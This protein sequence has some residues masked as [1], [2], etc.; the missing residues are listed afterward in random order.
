M[1][2]V[3]QLNTV[4]DCKKEFEKTIKELA[5][6]RHMWEVWSDFCELAAIGIFNPFERLYLTEHSPE[7]LGTRIQNHEDRYMSIVGRYSPEEI[8]LFPK[9]LGLVI[10]ALDIKPCDFLGSL[11]MDLDLGNHWIGQFFTPYNI[12]KLCAELTVG[13]GEQ[14]KKIQTMNEPAV[15]S[16]GMIIALCDC[17]H[18]KKINFQTQL[19]VTATDISATAAYMCYIQLS[20]IGCAAHVT[21][22]DTLAMTTNNVFATPFAYKNGW[23]PA[24]IFSEPEYV[25]R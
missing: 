22:G 10:Q 2:K 14:F 25:K 12:S 6:S 11:F 1:S 9:M 23:F 21:I 4:D 13:T 19:R 15:G 16:G 17:L 8:K 7:S 3:L 18:E 24:H 20:L 5:H